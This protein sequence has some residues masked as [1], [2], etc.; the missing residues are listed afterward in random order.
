MANLSV[1]GTENK[2]K[3]SRVESELD[4]C[5]WRAL[6]DPLH[7]GVVPVAGV[8]GVLD[9]DGPVGGDVDEA[10]VEGGG[11]GGGGD[12]AGREGAGGGNAHPVQLE[13]GPETLRM[14]PE[15]EFVSV[16]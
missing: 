7:V 10:G 5:V 6:Q 12:G 2:R 14:K 8:A 13:A 1:Q 11:G 9:D 4:P 15:V 3:L 16:S